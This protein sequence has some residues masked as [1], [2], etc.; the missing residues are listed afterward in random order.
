MQ[1]VFEKT[2]ELGQALLECEVYQHMKEAED[3]AMANE[4][5]AATMTRYLELRTQVQEMLSH[6]NP[7]PE[8]LKKLSDEMDAQQ[9]RLQLMDDIVAMNE[10]RGEFTNLINQINQILQFI[11]T[12]TIDNGDGGCTGSCSTCSG[13]KN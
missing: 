5:A 4:E 1:Q 13:C 8:A 3:R 9:E 2:R 11:V 12:G 10:A 7:D 6:E